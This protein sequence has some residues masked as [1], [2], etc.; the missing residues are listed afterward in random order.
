[1]PDYNATHMYM[2][3]CIFQ[4]K[5]VVSTGMTVIDSIRNVVL[6]SRI[7]DEEQ[8][9]LGSESAQLVVQR[10]S[11]KSLFNKEITSGNSK[12]VIPGDGSSLLADYTESY[13]DTQVETQP[14]TL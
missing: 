12:I 10:Q 7:P 3:H 11:K 9:V 6:A 1:M 14:L 2:S 4:S 13:I 5:V 8:I